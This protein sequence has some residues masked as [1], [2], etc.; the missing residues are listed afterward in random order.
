[1]D[2]EQKF[3]ADI[4]VMRELSAQIDIEDLKSKVRQDDNFRDSCQEMACFL[5]E[6]VTDQSS[7]VIC[8]YENPQRTVVL[9]FYARREIECSQRLLVSLPQDVTDEELYRIVPSEFDEYLNQS[10]WEENSSKLSHEG[11]PL[12]VAKINGTGDAYLQIRSTSGRL[13]IEKTVEQN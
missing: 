13:I 4:L 5:E 1:M 9:E 12:I 10:D 7:E 11:S 6:L 3:F 8:D 2:E